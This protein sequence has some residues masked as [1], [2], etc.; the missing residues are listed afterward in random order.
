MA[1][2]STAIE[3]RTQ[4]TGFDLDSK[5]DVTV[6]KTGQFQPVQNMQEFVQRLGNDSAKILEIVNSGL[7]D[8]ARQQ[9]A[10]NGDPWQTENEDGTLQPFAGTLLTEEKSK[11]FGATVLNLAKMMFGYPAD[12]PSDKSADAMETWRKAKE[13]AKAQAIGFVLSNPAAIEA[14]KKQ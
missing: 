13:T 12:K 5:S 14:L 9:L 4:K 1:A 6:V 2:P 7:Q 3:I 8:Y 11:Q 10:S